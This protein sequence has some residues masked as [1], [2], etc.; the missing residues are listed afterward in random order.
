MSNV[1]SRKIIAVV[2]AGGQ[3][4]RMGPVNKMLV[5]YHGQPL[6]CWAIDAAS[7]SQCSEVLVI[8]GHQPEAVAAVVDPAKATVV[9][10]PDYAQGQSQSIRV[11][12]AT[13]AG[14]DADGVVILLGDM[15]AVSAAH[16]N[17]LIAVISPQNHW[18]IA[19]ASEN[20]SR[21]NPVLFDKSLFA[22]L[23][24]LKGDMGARELIEKSADVMKLV[25]VGAAAR[26]DID[27][28]AQI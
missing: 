22:E 13:A 8:A 23:Q 15:P 26:L 17:Q 12:V 4:K 25:D 24:L 1:S 9:L 20:D 10:N 18:L 19:A 3:S 2:L 21:G 5:D 6:I 11:G 7:A 14:L 16:I 28:P 27:T